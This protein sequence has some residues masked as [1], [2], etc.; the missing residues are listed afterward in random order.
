[1]KKET[2]LMDMAGLIP[3]PS[4]KGQPV[5]ITRV[6]RKDIAIIGLGLKFPQADSVSQ[7]WDNL[8]QGKDCII[9]IPAGR[10][11]D[12]E[13]Y[14]RFMAVKMPPGAGEE[15]RRYE[16]AAYLERIDRFDY[17]FFR[18]SPREAAL[19]D[20]NQRIFLQTAWTAIED[21]GYGG[22]RL[23]GSQTG[24]YIGFGGDS[25]YKKLIA[26]VEPD[27]L[28]LAVP[29]NLPPIIASRLSYLLDLKGPSMLVNTVCSSSLVAVH[30]ACQ[31]I[32]SG[33]CDMAVAGGVQ[34]YVL[35]LR[36]AR[37]GIEA[38]DFRT[39]SFDNSSDGTGSGE[40]AAAILLK[41]LNKALSD[42]DH[43][44]AVIKGTAV[45]QDGRSIGISAPNPAA[46]AEVITRAWK[47]ADIDPETISYIEAHGT[48]T[49]LGDPIEIEGIR[50]AF[51]PY[52]Q[53][54]QFCA[55]GSV[56]SNMG[57]LDNSAG[58][59][60]LI[61]AVLSLTNKEIPPS[62]YFQR[63]NRKIAFHTSPVYVN[64]TLTSWKTNGHPRRCG[65][66]SFSFSGT[67]CHMVL[68][69]APPGQRSQEEN[70][71]EKPD[72]QETFDI[73]TLSAQT[74]EGLKQLLGQ[75]QTFLQENSLNMKPADVCFT[76]NCGRGHYAHRLA[77]IIKNEE[78][79]AAKLAGLDLHHK[80]NPGK[81][82]DGVYYGVHPAVLAQQQGQEA[83]IEI[84]R[85]QVQILTRTA[86]EKILASR[87]PRNDKRALTQLCELYVNGAEIQW[88]ELYRGCKCQ[89]LSLPTYPFTP[90]RCWLHIPDPEETGCYYTFD[91]KP[92][93]L[94]STGNPILPTEGVCLLLKDRKGMAET[95]SRGLQ[96]RGVPVVEVEVIPGSDFQKP[97]ENKY[98]VSGSQADYQRL[99]AETA[100][101]N[102]RQVIH[103]GSIHG[104][105]EIT[106]A[107]ELEKQLEAGVY[108][109]F[110]LVRAL[111]VR[112]SYR[113]G[114]DIVLI[115][116]FVHEVTRQEQGIHPGNAVLFGLGKVVNIEDFNLR[117][118]TVDIDDNTSPDAVMAEIDAGYTDYKVA[119]R[120][121]KRYVEELD[122][123][124]IPGADSGS[125][126]IPNTPGSETNHP[127]IQS[128]GVYVI[129]GG[130]G[131]LGLEV[132]G[133]LASQ[134][135]SHIALINRSAIPDRS[136]WP[137]IT[138][139]AGESALV[140]K[141]NAIKEIE[142][143]GAGVLCCQADV[144]K[145]QDIEKVLG[146]LRERFERI[147]GIVHCAAVG[148]GQ[149][150]KLI[151]EDDPGIFRLVMAPKVRGTWLLD[152]FT[153]QDQLDFFVVFSGAITLMGGMGSGSYT[154]A[155]TYLNSFA[156]YRGKNGLRTAAMCWAVWEESLEKDTIGFDKG[157]HLFR[158]Q[159]SGEI[160]RAFAE[161]LFSDVPLVI[162][163]RLN[164]KSE[165]F[166]LGSRL[167]FRLS[168]ELWER[169]EKHRQHPGRESAPS[170][171]RQ[172]PPVQLI[173]REH[174]NYLELE[175]QMAGIFAEFL[176]YREISVY[177]NF[178]ELGGDSIMA[179]KMIQAA[180]QRMAVN[181][182]L[183]DLLRFPT[184]AELV[185]NL[186][187]ENDGQSKEN[188][189][190]PNLST[191]SSGESPKGQAYLTLEPVEKKEYYP[192]SEFQKAVYILG[193]LRR[194]KSM[195]L[196]YHLPMALVI[197]GNVDKN[198]LWQIF[199]QLA[200][201]HETFRTWFEY[202]DKQPVQRI[203]DEMAIPLD[204]IE[205]GSHQGID[206][207]V[208]EFINPIDPG[209]APLFRIRL[210]KLEAPSSTGRYLLLMNT[211][212][213]ISDGQSGVN[214]MKDFAALYR[215]EELFPLKVQFKDIMEYRG[216]AGAGSVLEEQ[217]AYWL[218]IFKDGVPDL[219]IPLDSPRSWI[220][221]YKADNVF[222]QVGE[223]PYRRLN[224]WASRAGATLFMA[225]VAAF[226]VLMSIWTKDEDLVIG[227][228]AA[229]RRHP[230]LEP[231]V[232]CF[233]NILPL[234]NDS[235]KNKT[236]KELVGQ[237]KTNTIQA[238]ANQDYFFG[239]LVRALGIQKQLGRNPIYDVMVAM[240]VHE[241]PAMELD[242]LKFTPYDIAKNS[243]DVDLTLDVSEKER[244]LFLRW[245]YCC[246]VLKKET[247]E[248]WAAD[249]TK[250]LE[251]VSR[252]DDI[253]I[254]DIAPQL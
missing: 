148:S 54:K 108:S 49:K 123:V 208:S 187:R 118:R 48:G 106:S 222:T 186:N 65:V 18:V 70:Q 149:A 234:R 168:A 195:G 72:K 1:M 242:G 180:N 240:Q 172:A 33:E 158:V 147:N 104:N 140:K 198:R 31:G 15:D 128:R 52:T 138:A 94:L 188:R 85:Q 209:K 113:E 157:K 247:I 199:Q 58:I 221:S 134:G 253:F 141:I 95:I 42:R 228:P 73:L 183:E 239:D 40:G 152:R 252:D 112:G 176:G 204:Y 100:L 2:N 233:V 56:K 197:E 191:L 202:V 93:E 170:A 212:H 46:Q 25:E 34:V 19:M 76:A 21:A 246:K 201:R 135:C 26:D 250:I 166:L 251:T 59:A 116:D 47:D 39:R 45:N 32:R 79:L 109:L 150:G 16:E 35:P 29:G 83:G 184:I 218:G 243:T 248:S 127:T 196:T 179:A 129:T 117:C 41:P 9:P 194:G 60:G 80:D 114:I 27:S 227:V 142:K 162:F 38:A 200:Q 230:Q 139:G 74:P 77:I 12:V 36:Q 103:L 131:G 232:G 216:H 37:V 53:K 3:G 8:R 67:N 215:G 63:P 82:L 120:K 205:V 244:G 155:N 92:Q 178:Y 214:L 237:V 99:L 98:R 11:Q 78:D 102:L 146:F 71:I 44:Y 107:A 217:K 190:D 122:R 13:A 24:V 164:Y 97:G 137:S 254:K 86:N 110:Y 55:I 96:E 119:Y 121:G 210:V 224:R 43:I 61:K 87:N 17:G 169:V 7:F 203:H 111:Q 10:K 20:P 171:G 62:L 238:F 101:E 23:E 81:G 5:K 151:K 143:K 245:E 145:Q 14:F 50:Q 136:Q 22:G 185:S 182:A 220:K 193:Q 207:L 30:L 167:P 192:A 88:D 28:S 133:W 153:R 125:H 115:S 144:S 89:R 165:I 66:S 249:Y 211:H 225:M 84:P 226:H 236:F 223:G 235:S 219:K 126:N 241:Q 189:Q 213:S 57:H 206:S 154:A 181:L 91:W 124:D 64:D 174:G 75:C 229:G 105:E 159:S 90:H 175:R 156:S 130:T 177:D 231:L 160:L 173:G 6:S 161:I 163:G 132:A 68:E 4:G 51:A 69:E